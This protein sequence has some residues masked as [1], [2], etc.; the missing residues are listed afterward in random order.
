MIASAGDDGKEPDGDENYGKAAMIANAGDRDEKAL[1]AAS[2]SSLYTYLT[3]ESDEDLE[4][5]D[6]VDQLIK[7]AKS[8]GSKRGG[9]ATS[10]AVRMSN[11]PRGKADIDK[12]CSCGCG[13]KPSDR[14][15]PG[16][17][18]VGSKITMACWMKGQVCQLCSS[19]KKKNSSIRN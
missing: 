9:K 13:R 6:L 4:T 19:K 17:G 18:S 14:N 16:C 8:K 10:N 11:R 3:E 15:C 1:S 7:K 12:E 2:S 5:D